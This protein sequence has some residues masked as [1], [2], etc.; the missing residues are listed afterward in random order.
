MSLINLVCVIIHLWQRAW[1]LCFILLRNKESW[2]L[3][4]F[5]KI[6]C[7][8]WFC[9]FPLLVSRSAIAIA[10]G[11]LTL[12]PLKSK[13]YQIWSHT[14]IHEQPISQPRAYFVANFI[15]S[16]YLSVRGCPNKEAQLATV[17]EAPTQRNWNEW[18]L[19][20]IMFPL[21]APIRIKNIDNSTFLGLVG[22]SISS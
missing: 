10:N 14:K 2:P 6:W 9:F 12:T 15:G 1:P 5:I 21:V 16:F 17:T 4:S 8:D 20:S 22:A 13:N 3:K 18:S 7:F 19:I 11:T